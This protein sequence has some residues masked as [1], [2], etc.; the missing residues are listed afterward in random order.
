[1]PHFQFLDG[2]QLPLEDECF[3]RSAFHIIQAK[4][5]LA[6]GETEHGIAVLYDAL[7]HAMKHFLLRQKVNPAA[8]DETLA[9]EA[10]TR[11]NRNFPFKQFQ[12][13]MERVIDGD[14]EEIDP[15][16]YEKAADLVIEF[17]IPIFPSTEAIEKEL[18]TS[19]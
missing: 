16:I 4:E 8:D 19:R 1:M 13:T 17:G 6:K 10:L 14:T 2:L 7:L 3:F 9:H 12:E 15:N 11:I 18:I 5:I